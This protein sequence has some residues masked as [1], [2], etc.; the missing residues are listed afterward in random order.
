[1]LKI[2]SVIYFI[3]SNEI[4]SQGK[5]PASSLLVYFSSP[6]VL[7]WVCGRAFRPVVPGPLGILPG[8]YG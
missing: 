8:I 1:M 2:P 7:V 5:K 3:A 4:I 6:F